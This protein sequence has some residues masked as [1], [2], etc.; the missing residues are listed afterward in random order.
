ME[1]LHERAVRAAAQYVGRKG[2]EVLDESW[3]TEALAGRIDLV[4][5]DEG[6]IVFVE[7]TASSVAEGGFAEARLAREQLEVLAATWLAGNSEECNVPV[8]FDAVA[9]RLRRERQVRELAAAVPHGGRAQVPGRRRV[10]AE[11]G[12]LGDAGLGAVAVEA[13]GAQAAMF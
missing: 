2:Y 8:R 3:S 11:H 12:E 4:A 10:Q 5:E 7:V 6:T 9:D 1:N 13:A